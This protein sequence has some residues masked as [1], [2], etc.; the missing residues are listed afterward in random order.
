MAITRVSYHILKQ[1]VALGAIPKGGSILE[2]GEANWYGDFPIEDIEKDVMEM[3][4]DVNEQTELLSQ[5]RDTDNPIHAFNVCKVI[6]RVLFAA[7]RITAID[8]RGTDAAIKSDLNEPVTTDG[9][10][11]ITINNGTAEHVFNI[12]QV[13]KTIHEQTALNGVMIHEAPFTGW[14]NHGF[15][16]LQPTLYYD[17][18]AANSYNILGTFCCEHV[19]PKIIQIDS[20]LH[21]LELVEKKEI[22]TNSVLFVLMRKT[23][24]EPFKY[25]MQGYYDDR[26]D[27]KQEDAWK[28]LRVN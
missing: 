3:V 19:P 16:N 8:L 21:L 17:I 15:F 22:P 28:K 10:F 27:A 6:Y 18:A 25:P 13:F 24:E 4:P 11:N 7:D 26:L 2:L 14:Y 5:L 9:P 20:P 1:A 23:S 12:G